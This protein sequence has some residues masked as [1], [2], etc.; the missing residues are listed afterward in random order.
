MSA[1]GAAGSAAL[2]GRL[3]PPLV[4]P[5]QP[6]SRMMRATR[7]RDVDP[8]ALL[9]SARTFGAPWTPRPAAHIS[10]IFPAS[11]ASL[12]PCALGRLFLHAQ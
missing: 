11:P 3:A 2:L 4:V 10:E 6:L 5:A 8:P 1:C 7:L 12:S 9:S